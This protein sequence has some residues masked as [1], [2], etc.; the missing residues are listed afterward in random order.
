MCLV[1]GK[2]SRY[3]ETLTSNASVISLLESSSMCNVM[4][5]VNIPVRDRVS[6]LRMVIVI[7]YSRTSDGILQYGY[8]IT[9]T[10]TQAQSK[11]IRD[12]KI[13]IFALNNETVIDCVKTCA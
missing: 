8:P 6:D 9:A 11:S 4:C 1:I 2:L 5:R 7:I 13:N 10:T 3:S 12:I